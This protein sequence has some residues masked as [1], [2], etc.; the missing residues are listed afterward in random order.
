MANWPSLAKNRELFDGDVDSNISFASVKLN[1]VVDKKSGK[2]AV[3][4]TGGPFIR[5]LGDFRYQTAEGKPRKF[6]QTTLFTWTSKMS[7]PSFSIPAGPTRQGGTCPAST[8]EAI[9]KEGSYTAYSVPL[10]QTPEGQAFICDV[11]YAGKGRYLM[12]KAMSLGQ[13]AKLRW[14]ER[15]LR[16]GSFVRKM[17]E[18][19]GALLDP[20]VEELLLSQLVSNQYFRIHDS[21]DFFSPDYYK[22]WVE[23]C[24]NLKDIHFWA[25]TR[26][27]VYEKWRRVFSNYPP[28]PNLALRPS[29]LFTSAVPPAIPDL[30]AGSGSVEG[31][32]DAPVWNCPAYEGE[33]E[34]SCAAARCRVC[35]D[36]PKKPVNYM[37]H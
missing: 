9:E 36:A 27:W 32:M 25:P 31:R 11:C 29:A 28:P 3:T 30:A 35:W 21:G 2:E 10:K 33:N 12:Y 24:R 14:V 34:H 18:A 19:L 1:R 23:V 8:R 13:T 7:C 20:A 22:A 26:M 15:T 17:S 6:G 5:I 16:D 4:I 37:T